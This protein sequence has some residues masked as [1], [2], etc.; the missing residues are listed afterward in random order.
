[1]TEA[2]IRISRGGCAIGLRRF[3]W[4]VLVSGLLGVVFG[5]CGGSGDGVE[6][7]HVSGTVSYDGSPVPHGTILFTPDA[8]KGNSGPAGYS[9]I[10]DG[11]YDTAISG[12]GTVGGPHIAV[13]SGDDGQ[14]RYE[15]EFGEEVAV[16]LFPEFRIEV[17]LPRSSTAIEFEVPTSVSPRAP[18]RVGGDGS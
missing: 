4:V 1:M 8:A 14:P 12:K 15:E 9:T 7:F 11:S 6:R 3:D 17:D 13:I 10:Q 5:G 18:R 2:K 16:P